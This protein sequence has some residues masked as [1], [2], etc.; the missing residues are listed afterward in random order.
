MLRLSMKRLQ[1]SEETRVTPRA[2][3]GPTGGDVGVEK[4]AQRWKSY[5]ILWL[6]LQ[7]IHVGVQ[8]G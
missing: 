4:R 8:S 5:V 3:R 2:W 1:F 7:E 6:L